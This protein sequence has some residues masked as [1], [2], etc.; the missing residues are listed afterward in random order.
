MFSGNPP[1][2]VSLNLEQDGSKLETTD[3]LRWSFKDRTAVIRG[4]GTLYLAAK[5]RPPAS[6]PQTPITRG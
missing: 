4:P 6:K 2:N 3:S 5:N 1:Q